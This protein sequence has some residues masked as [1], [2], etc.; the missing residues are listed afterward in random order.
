MRRAAVSYM[1]AQRDAATRELETGPDDHVVIS[2]SFDD[3]NH[4]VYAPTRLFD[5]A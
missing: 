4:R 1:V 3:T 5:A 2:V